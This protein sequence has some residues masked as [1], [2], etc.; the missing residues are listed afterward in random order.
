MPGPNRATQLRRVGL[1]GCWLGAGGRG[2]GGLR[3]IGTAGPRTAQRVDSNGQCSSRV[4]RHCEPPPPHPKRANPSTCS[5]RKQAAKILTWAHIFAGASPSAGFP[6]AATRT[7]KPNVRTACHPT[8]ANS[9]TPRFPDAIHPPGIRAFKVCS[10]RK[11]AQKRCGVG[12]GSTVGEHAGMLVRA[13][14]RGGSPGER[15]AR[16]AGEDGR[17]GAED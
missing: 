17:G 2:R 13:E 3:D 10:C 1:L 12:R 14:D 9:G 16:G 15:L 5:A 11:Q 8:G 6:H 4:L 7:S